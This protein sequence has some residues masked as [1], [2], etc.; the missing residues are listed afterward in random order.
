MVP[1]TPVPVI[2][3]QLYLVLQIID[4]NPQTESVVL[5][6]RDMSGRVPYKCRKSNPF[7]DLVK[8]GINRGHV[9]K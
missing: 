3:R 6:V 8:R 4:I 2:P 9:I 5:R 1:L 7:G